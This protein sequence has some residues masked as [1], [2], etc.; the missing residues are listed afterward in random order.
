MIPAAFEYLC[1]AGVEE[2]VRMLALGGAKAQVLAG[3]QS[4]LPMM[5]LRQATPALVV[6]L[7]RVPQLCGV[8]E[9]A[10]S[11]HI[12]AMTTHHDVLHSALVRRHA[13]LLAAAT[14]TVGDPAVRHRG[15]LGGALAHAD[16]ASDLPAVVLALDGELMAEGPRGL[17]AI[18]AAEFFVGRLRT[19]LEPGELL[20]GIRVPK[21]GAGWGFH[22]EKFRHSA[23][24][25]AVVSVAVAVRR[26]ASGIAEARIALA[27]M[28]TTPLRAPAA[29]AALVGAD[30]TVAFVARAA[31]AAADGTSPASGPGITREYRT[32]L[33]RVLTRRGVLA[34][35]GLGADGTSPVH[36]RSFRIR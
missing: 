21:L 22:Y 33:A 36:E 32:H 19:A 5:R 6:D 9:E 16:P 17:R 13:P 31:E 20:V 12:G 34:A 29:E 15:T 3:G 18:P 30:A 8:R 23:Q 26:E 24:A 25:S 4:L 11:L 10:R 7:G 1:P 14:E 28:G 27:N 35:A 2:A